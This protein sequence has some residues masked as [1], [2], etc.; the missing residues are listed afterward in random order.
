MDQFLCEQGLRSY[1]NVPLIA[2][3]ELVGCLNVCSGA[4][5]AFTA[6][7]RE[8]AQE[9]AEVLAL[10]IDQAHLHEEVKRRA[11]E[12]EQRV[13]ERTRELQDINAELESF[14]YSI[15]HDLRTPLRGI[16]GYIGIL[17]EDHAGTL[18]TEGKR[19]LNVIRESAE[20]LGQL[21]KDLLAFSRVSRQEINMTELD[22][23][24]LARSA[25]HQLEDSL[26]GRALEFNLKEL[27]PSHGD[28]AMIRQVFVNLFSNAF[29]FTRRKESAVVEVAGQAEEAECVYCIK[30]NGVGFRM[31]QAHKIFG[32]F[33]RLHRSREYEGTGAGLAI[34]QRIIRRHGGRVWVDGTPGVGATVFFALPSSVQM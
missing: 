1:M 6:E 21:I 29:K 33:Q 2:Q 32:V 3:D 16:T 30:D 9:L 28:P 11:E 7:A 24:R 31:E 4:A 18:D 12:L 27:P 8:I 23:T 14:S 5:G 15:A 13:T 10:A 17:L 25:F 19:L 20:H 26:K 22:M 34:V